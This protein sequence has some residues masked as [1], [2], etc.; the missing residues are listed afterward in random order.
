MGQESGVNS[1]GQRMAIKVGRRQPTAAPSQGSFLRDRKIS[2]MQHT[3]LEE[4]S[5]EVTNG[6]AGGPEGQQHRRSFVMARRV[7]CMAA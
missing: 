2:W 1:R 7:S 3:Q 5:L 4:Q 6:K